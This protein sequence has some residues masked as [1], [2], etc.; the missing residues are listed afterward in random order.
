MLRTFLKLMAVGVLAVVGAVALYAY[1]DFSAT[2]RKMAALEKEKARLEEQKSRLQEVVRHLGSEKR[3]AEVLVTD[4][5]TDPAGKTTTTLLFVEYAHDGS[6]LTPKTFTIEG[7]TAHIDALVVKFDGKF[8]E[9]KDPLRGHSVALFY[10]LF[11][12]HQNPADAHPIDAPGSVPDV[13][14]G[15]NLD[16]QTRAFEQELWKNFWRL[17]DDPRYRDSMGVRVAQGESPWTRFEKDRLYTISIESDGGLNLTSEPLKGI[18]REALKQQQRG[19][20]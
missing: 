14:R 1:H 17:V 13:Y 18:Y 11:G 16:P 8:V 2:S 12:D 3:V 10:R 5:T 19:A 7:K 15:A 6:A 9:D 20:T 4:Q